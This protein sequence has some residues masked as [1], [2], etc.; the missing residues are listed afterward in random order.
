MEILSPDSVAQ[1]E[2][3]HLGSLSVDFLARD[4]EGPGSQGRA[5]INGLINGGQAAPQGSRHRVQRVSECLVTSAVFPTSHPHRAQAGGLEPAPQHPHRSRVRAGS[6]TGRHAG[7]RQCTPGARGDQGQG[8]GQVPGA[9]RLQRAA[10]FLL[11]FS[12]LNLVTRRNLP[13][14]LRLERSSSTFCGG[15][16]NGASQTPVCPGLAPAAD[17]RAAAKRPVL[18]LLLEFQSWTDPHF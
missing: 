5:M 9:P 11:F 2:K 4:H 10:L 3:H 17:G 13:L 16:G 15:G 12:F 14:R 7:V 8:R 1:G 6:G 18:V